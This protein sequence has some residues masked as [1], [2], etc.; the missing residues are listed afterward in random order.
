MGS[1]QI[2]MNNNEYILELF[3]IDGQTIPRS[4]DYLFIIKLLS[5]SPKYKRRN[6]F[7]LF[8]DENSF[9]NFYLREDPN[10]KYYHPVENN[11]VEILDHWKFKWNIRY[12]K[13][14]N[15]FIKRYYDARIFIRNIKKSSNCFYRVTFQDI[16]ICDGNEMI[17]NDNYKKLNNSM[18]YP[19][20]LKDDLII[21][22][23]ADYWDLVI[24]NLEVEKI[25][26]N[27]KY[28]LCPMDGVVVPARISI[29]S[30]LETWRMLC[31]REWELKVCPSCLFTFSEELICMS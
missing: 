13:T 4:S 7:S 5:H 11:R 22:H 31:G 29:K 16:I 15:K 2:K 8:F 18:K 19:I 14:L 26:D 25:S 6:Y 23:I 12:N 17:I 9:K 27:E 28:N 24:H 21:D 20:K 1:E 30:P 10:K 3:P